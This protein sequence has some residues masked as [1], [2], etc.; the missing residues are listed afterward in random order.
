MERWKSDMVQR[1]GTTAEAVRKNAAKT[2]TSN[3]LVQPLEAK[4]LIKYFEKFLACDGGKT[5]AYCG[6]AFAH[7][8][9]LM[10]HQQWRQAED[11]AALM[12]VAVEQVTINGG[13]WHYAWLLTHLDQPSTEM[14]DR[15]PTRDRLRPF[16]KLA[17][18]TWAAAVVAYTKDAAAMNELLTKDK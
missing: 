13:K 11:L 15:K 2:V 1:P 3:P 17:E 14:V 5:L 12:C 6:M 16:A 4:S 7:V 8:M 18:P 10:A 9:D